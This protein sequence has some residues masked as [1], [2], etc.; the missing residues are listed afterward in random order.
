MFI[1]SPHIATVEGVGV[2]LNLDYLQLS[3][4]ATLATPSDGGAY[5]ANSED[6]SFPPFK[7]VFPP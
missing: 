2:T 7:Y 4:L 1:T 5:S 6:P 3:A